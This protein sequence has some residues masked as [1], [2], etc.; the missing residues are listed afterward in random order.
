MTDTSPST[1]TI[2][3]AGTRPLMDPVMGVQLAGRSY[4][5]CL[6]PH[7]DTA[8]SILLRAMSLCQA[9]GFQI[10]WESRFGFR[11]WHSW[12]PIGDCFS[13][14]VFARNTLLLSWEMKVLFRSFPSTVTMRYW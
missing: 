9:V 1:F 7:D 8:L 5:H 4:P 11:A 6:A 14:C 2:L 10:S 13:V 3:V 12:E